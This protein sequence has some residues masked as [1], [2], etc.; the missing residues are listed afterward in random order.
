MHFEVFKDRETVD[1]LRY[2]DVTQLKFDDL[3]TRYRY[4]YVEDLKLKY[5]NKINMNRFERFFIS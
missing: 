4:K 1:P 5:G 2:M 3:P